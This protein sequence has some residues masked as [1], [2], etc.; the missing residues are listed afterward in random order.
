MNL[1]M[2]FDESI[3]GGTI[4]FLAPVRFTSCWMG[5]PCWDD[6]NS[7]GSFPHSVNSTSGLILAYGISY[8]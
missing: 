5:G 3:L 2:N 4:A 7:H 1:G 8:H 6:D